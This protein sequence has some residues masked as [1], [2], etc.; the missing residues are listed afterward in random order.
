MILL[1]LAIAMIVATPPVPSQDSL[2]IKTYALERPWFVFIRHLSG[3][4]DA[5]PIDLSHCSLK[6]GSID[7]R[8]F[9]RAC[10][11]AKDLWKLSGEC[12]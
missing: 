10:E 1:R 4:P 5:G 7:V 2:I 8:S 9:A 6:N 11:A 12:R 3:C